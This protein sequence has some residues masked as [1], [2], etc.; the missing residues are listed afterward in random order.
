LLVLYTPPLT[1]GQTYWF[2]VGGPNIGQDLSAPGDSVATLRSSVGVVGTNIAGSDGCSTASPNPSRSWW[3]GSCF[4]ATIP[5]TYTTPTSFW[6]IVRS[7]SITSASTATIRAQRGAT[8]VDVACSGSS[9]Q[10]GCWTTLGNNLSFGAA[11]SGIGTSQ[12]NYHFETRERPGTSSATYQMIGFAPSAA[13]W[14][15]RIGA[16]SNHSNLVG[17][18]AEFLGPLPS[19]ITSSGIA[20]AGAFGGTSSP[21]DFVR[22]DR[23]TL[24]GGSTFGTDQDGDG[25]G[26]ALETVL[27]TC[28]SPTAPAYCASLRGC[29]TTAPSCQPGETCGPLSY[30]CL[31]SRRDS[32]Q[33]GFEDQLEFYGYQNGIDNLS[34]MARFGA[35]PA[36]YDVFLE[37]D[38]S[39]STNAVMGTT[40]SYDDDSYVDWFEANQFATSFRAST[41]TSGGFVNPNGVRGITTHL[42]VA[43]PPAGALAGQPALDNPLYGV[44]GGASCISS[45]SCTTNAQCTFDGVPGVCGVNAP[46][47]RMRCI[48]LNTL[49]AFQ[50]NQRRWLFRQAHMLVGRGAGQ[51]GGNYHFYVGTAAGAIHELGH[52]GQLGHSGPSYNYYTEHN[53]SPLFATTMNYRA[54]GIGV[55]EVINGLS[56]LPALETDRLETLAFSGQ[57]SSSDP[58]S[59]AETCFSALS[60]DQEEALRTYGQLGFLSRPNASGTCVDIDWDRDGSYLASGTTTINQPWLHPTRVDGSLENHRLRRWTAGNVAWRRVDRASEVV[61]TSSTRRL[62]RNELVTPTPSSEGRL[63]LS[64]GSTFSCPSTPQAAP[65]DR[66]SPCDFASGTSAALAIAGN[67]IQTR[68]FAACDIASPVSGDS[69][70]I[71]WQESG[72]SNLRWGRLD[73]TSVTFAASGLIPLSAARTPIDSTAL[74]GLARTTSGAVLVYRNAAGALVEQVLTWSGTAASWTAPTALASTIWTGMNGSAGLTHVYGSSDFTAGV[75]MAVQVGTLMTLYR[76]TGAAAWTSVSSLSTPAAIRG[77]PV[78]EIGYPWSHGGTARRRVSLFA[79]FSDRWRVQVIDSNLSSTTFQGTGSQMPGWHDFDNTDRS[80]ATTSAALDATSSPF[81]MRGA[82]YDL[83]PQAIVLNVGGG[84]ATCPAGSVATAV[85]SRSVCFTSGVPIYL[86]PLGAIQTASIDCGSSTTI[87]S[88]P[89]ATDGVCPTGYAC[90]AA[91]ADRSICTLNGFVPMLEQRIPFV[92]GMLPMRI[93]QQNEWPQMRYGFC[94]TGRALRSAAFT[95]SQYQYPQSGLPGVSATSVCTPAPTY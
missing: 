22:N 77:Q 5:S 31:A 40:C 23:G 91:S 93:E 57:T 16:I 11:V 42:D 83:A 41:A 48:Q 67:P 8:F 35:D 75:Y 18:T 53:F 79:R 89:T 86:D 69:A 59:V 55:K 78:M 84:P 63:T 73:G 64:S 61:V 74:L 37:V 27:Q 24:P 60:I 44:W 32:D 47:E 54:A 43:P 45:P 29:S 14:D 7:Y 17:T 62:I 39:D 72:S 80:M 10:T 6:L 88:V 19:G 65:A 50:T 30:L 94:Q 90:T 13:S 95:P 12:T 81:G 21:L 66:Y 38:I 56:S 87:P 52:L 28:D 4:S 49:G 46:G 34:N 2:E 82:D 70:L 76:R 36:Q 68:N 33:D 3:R 58:M 9:I 1:G 51:T 85:G 26:N 71:V 15:I 20:F 25:L 92:D